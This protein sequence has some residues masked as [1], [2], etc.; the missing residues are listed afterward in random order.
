M[1]QGHR[2]NPGQV[3]SDQLAEGR[4]RAVTGV[5]F[6]QFPIVHNAQYLLPLNPRQRKKGTINLV[7][8]ARMRLNVGRLK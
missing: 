3:A 7:P 5:S 6:K 1:A 2:I 4:F 8:F